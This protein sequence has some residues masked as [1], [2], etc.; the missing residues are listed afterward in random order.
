VKATVNKCRR[1]YKS[2]DL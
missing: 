1:F 2:G